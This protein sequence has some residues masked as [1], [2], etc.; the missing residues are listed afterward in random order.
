MKRK[1]YLMLIVLLGLSMLSGCFF[2]GEDKEPDPE[3]PLHAIAL[4][5]MND[6]EGWIWTG[7][8]HPRSMEITD[9]TLLVTQQF[10]GGGGNGGIRKTFTVDLDEY[11]IIEFAFESITPGPNNWMSLY[12]GFAGASEQMRLQKSTSGDVQPFDQVDPAGT[13]RINVTEKFGL[14]GVQ[15]LDLYIAVFGAGEC[16]MQIDKIRALDN[17]YAANL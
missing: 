13:F 14:T 3:E 9:G 12:L 8:A 5:D 17:T 2:K 10:P 7:S 4:T 1:L 16:K 6:S 15:D 11:P